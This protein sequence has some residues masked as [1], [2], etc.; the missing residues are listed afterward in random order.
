MF[1]NFFYKLRDVGIPVTP[2]SFLRL[3]KALNLGLVNSLEEFYTSARSLLIKSERYF[4]LY[5]QVFAYHFRG[6]E[7]P[8]PEGIEL[9]EAAKINENGG[10]YQGQDRFE[11][12]K[13]MWEDMRAEGL[14]IKEEPYTTT[15]PRFMFRP[16][17]SLAS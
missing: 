15:I 13:N 16:M 11:A 7:L 1:V 4:D 5:D 17:I 8:D 10:K 9:D 12:R 3:Q 6:V 2:T 14:V